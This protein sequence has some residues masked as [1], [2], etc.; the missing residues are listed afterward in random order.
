M[1]TS[2]GLIFRVV[3]AAGLRARAVNPCDCSKSLASLPAAGGGA[4]IAGAVPRLLAGLNIALLATPFTVIGG[5]GLW[6]NFLASRPRVFSSDV[7]V[8]KPGKRLDA[9]GVRI[10]IG[11]ALGTS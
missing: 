3:A 6:N 2:E 4:A 8:E 9:D 5:I 1:E 10:C 11:L 7:T